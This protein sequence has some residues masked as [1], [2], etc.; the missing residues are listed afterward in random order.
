MAE[1]SD[2]RTL[3]PWA[4]LSHP[5]YR[6]LWLAVLVSNIG[7]WM[8][9]VGAQWVLVTDA[10]AAALVPLVQTATT[11]PVALLALPG[12][13]L[14]DSFDKRRLLIGVQTFQV[15]AA[16]VLTVMSVVG[17]LRPWSLLLLT[18]ALGA[19]AALT[20]PAYQS[21]LPELVPHEE[22]PAAAG[23]SAI[24]MNLARSIGPACAGLIIAQTGPS[25]I[26]ALNALSFGVFG[27]ML[28]RWKRPLDE[29]PRR[30]EP[31]GSALRSGARYVRHAPAL[32]RMLVA[33]SLFAVPA[34][35]VWSLLPLVAT[36]RLGLGS[37]G[38][39]V[40]M[41]AMGIGAVVGA[42]LLPRLRRHWETN[43]LVSVG[44]LVYAA[45]TAAVVL[46]RPLPLVVLA[47]LP[48]GAG[49]ILVLSTMNVSVQFYLPG[50]V[51]GRGL[52]I[53]QIVLFGSQA[54]G[55]A[56][57]GFV[58]QQLGLV[59]AHVMAAGVMALAATSLAVKPLIETSTLDRTPTNYWSEPRL[60]HQ[61]DDAA[62]PVLISV[63]Y[64]VAVEYHADF[65]E[66]MRVVRRSRLRTGAVSWGLYQ[67]GESPESFTEQ[68]VVLTW[69]EHLRQHTGRLTASDR[70]VEQRARQLSVP[71]PV[72]SHLFPALGK[73]SRRAML[74]PIGPGP[75]GGA[76]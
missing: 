27:V 21:L 51:R 38:Y 41:A 34:M 73:R 65:L 43:A 69:A 57:W 35:A 7:T 23:L 26:F 12:G 16:C 70:A 55:A 50:W 39:G 9:T 45:A 42:M 52:A 31:F 63:T 53:Y 58:A 1:A 3:G 17:G 8:Q 60:A 36:R 56:L 13:V 64:T 66:A 19:G 32:R 59:V 11:L 28:M 72:G 30:P 37:G 75:V 46:V 29:S 40:L 74:Y 47:L 76:N 62:G 54:V 2:I 15:L 4:P 5:A 10:R 24:S 33:V 61:P 67:V 25:A 14:A 18:F 68:Y 71:P 48:V 49:W 22:I 6:A 44:S 20:A